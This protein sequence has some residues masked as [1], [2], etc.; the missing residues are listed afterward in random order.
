VTELAPALQIIVR[1]HPTLPDDWFQASIRHEW[2]E[3]E[4]LTPVRLDLIADN[5]EPG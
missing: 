3:G 1:D 5:S 2:C 4:K